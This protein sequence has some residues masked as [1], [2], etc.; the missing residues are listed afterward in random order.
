MVLVH[1]T[2]IHR[3]S[4]ATKVAAKKTAKGYTLSDESCDQCEMPLMTLNGKSEC[5]VCP[6]IKKWVQRKNEAN[7]QKKQADD[8]R[9][10][11]ET[12]NKEAEIREEEEE[13]APVEIIDIEDKPEVVVEIVDTVESKQSEAQSE[14]LKID[15]NNSA[16]K[17]E[18]LQIDSRNS[19]DSGSF[20]GRFASMNVSNSA[21]TESE[22]SSAQCYSMSK[23]DSD[24]SEDTDAIR[25]RARQIILDARGRGEWG[26][27]DSND[28]DEDDS[29][30]GTSIKSY[31]QSWDDGKVSYSNEYEE[32][33]MIQERAADI[34][35]RARKDL[36]AE[37]GSEFPPAAI[38]SPRIDHDEVSA[39]DSIHSMPHVFA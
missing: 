12:A 28:E 31:S 15:S 34:I 16:D 39:E 29:D 26:G 3:H 6:A 11:V 17:S 38:L 35:N 21:S 8:A 27:A 23:T 7:A 14:V 13:E 19:N 1:H 36:Q 32:D 30:N 2:L 24:D 25:A 37:Q 33:C 9:E 5:K 20:V 18:V 22:A 10:A 4:I